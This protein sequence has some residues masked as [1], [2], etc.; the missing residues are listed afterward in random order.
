MKTKRKTTSNWE[1]KNNEKKIC[2]AIWQNFVCVLEADNDWGVVP[3]MKA[4]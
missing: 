1:K 4:Q 3:K 2:I